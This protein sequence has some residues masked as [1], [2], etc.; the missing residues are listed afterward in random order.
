MISLLSFL[1]ILPVLTPS[2][3]TKAIG[4][5]SLPILSMLLLI[6]PLPPPLPDLVN[7]SPFT[8]LQLSM[9]LSKCFL[10]YLKVFPALNLILPSVTTTS[11]PT[12][13]AILHIYRPTLSNHTHPN[14]TLS[15]LICSFQYSKKITSCFSRA[16][17]IFAFCVEKGTTMGTFYHLINCEPHDFQV[18]NKLECDTKPSFPGGIVCVEITISW[19]S[20]NFTCLSELHLADEI[21]NNKRLCFRSN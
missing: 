19:L 9:S 6:F 20:M 7:R 21:E 8:D 13:P 5:N 16:S 3:C 1:P 12:T 2:S 15:S 11:S 17:T 4:Q 18:L 10:G 14:A